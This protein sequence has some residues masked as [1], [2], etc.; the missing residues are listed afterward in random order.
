MPPDEP[1]GREEDDESVSSCAPSV[2][3]YL[4]D[5]PRTPKRPMSYL[6]PRNPSLVTEALYVSIGLAVISLG[7][8]IGYR[9]VRGRR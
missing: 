3:S 7:V 9:V 1:K 8:Y 6:D 5:V 4:D 2:H